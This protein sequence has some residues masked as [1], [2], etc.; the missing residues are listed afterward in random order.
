MQQNEIVKRDFKEQLSNNKINLFKAYIDNLR[1]N[2]SH[3]SSAII[4]CVN[5]KKATSF[6]TAKKIIYLISAGQ[7]LLLTLVGFI[8]GIYFVL[9]NRK[10][11]VLFA[12]VGFLM[13]YIILV[14]GIS[15]GQGDRFSIVIYPFCI[16]LI[17]KFL[18]EIKLFSAP[19]QK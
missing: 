16:L 8:L 10:A 1:S 5:E 7:N 9:K 13:I 6:E 3:G 14:S 17:A 4:D 15:C 19:L 11:N 18:Q 12:N 2:V